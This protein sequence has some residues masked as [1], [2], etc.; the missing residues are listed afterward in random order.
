MRSV[1]RT[2]KIIRKEKRSTSGTTHQLVQ[3]PQKTNSL[4]STSLAMPTTVV[5]LKQKS[6]HPT[7]QTTTQTLLY[8][9]SWATSSTLKNTKTTSNLTTASKKACNKSKAKT[10][11][12]TISPNLLPSSPTICVSSNLMPQWSQSNTRYLPPGMVGST[13][14]KQLSQSR[15]RRHVCLRWTRRSLRAERRSRVS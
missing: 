1:Q 8:R 9:S 3:I 14:P 5:S 2:Y 12:A 15:N 7:H 10:T 13:F 6:P 4:E 11:Q